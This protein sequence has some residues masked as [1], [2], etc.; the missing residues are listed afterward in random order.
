MTRLGLVLVLVAAKGAKAPPAFKLDAPLVERAKVLSQAAVAPLS[1]EAICGHLERTRAL[2]ED[3]TKA[4]GAYFPKAGISEDSADE[5]VMQAVQKEAERAAVPGLVVTANNNEFVEVDARFGLAGF[6]KGAQLSASSSAFLSAAAPLEPGSPIS[7]AERQVTDVQVCGELTGV[8][9][10]LPALSKAWL[11]APA[12][13]QKDYAPR[14]QAVLD[15][16]AGSNCLCDGEA[17]VK[18]QQSEIARAVATFPKGTLHAGKR[19]KGEVQYRCT[20]N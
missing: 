19:A 10:M 7:M 9:A 15:E 11:S 12:C 18:A 1:D 16:V 5:A 14:L 2:A 17:Q 8:V 4:M 3:V 20:P 13:L 6:L